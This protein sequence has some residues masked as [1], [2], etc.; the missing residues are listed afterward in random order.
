MR[1][2]ILFLVQENVIDLDIDAVVN[3]VDLAPWKMEA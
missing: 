2:F 3:L 1:I